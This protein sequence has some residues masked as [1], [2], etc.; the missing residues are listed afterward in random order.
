MKILV[1]NGSPRPKGSTRK[2]I[3][4]FCE[5]AASVG[6][7]VDVVDVCRKQIRGCMACEYCHTKGRGACVQKDD[8]QEIYDLLK[9][10][11]MLVLASPIYY[12]GISGQLKCV[13]DRLYAAAY[14]A[15]PPRLKKVAMF[16][17]SGDADM[18]RGAMFSYEGDFL[19]YLG[20]EDMG[21]FTAH[22]AENGSAA[23]QKELRDFGTSLK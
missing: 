1:L 9:D 8:M 6:H 3:D 21:V 17:S 16:L 11:E 10:T 4:A 22:G 23:K 7:Q 15:K 14:P 2:M 20:L 13:V 5:G 18:Y 12:H 19:D